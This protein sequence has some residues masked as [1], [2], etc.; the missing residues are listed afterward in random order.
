MEELQAEM[1][2]VKA[3]WGKE[4]ELSKAEKGAPGFPFPVAV[5]RYAPQPEHAAMWDCEELPF[6]L[7]IFEKEVENLPVSVEVP[8][9]FP[10]D[11]SS[12]MERAIETE[13]RK[14][15]GKK[16]K[17]N[18][19]MVEE[20]CEWVEAKFG[21]LLRLNPEYVDHYFGCDAAGASM[22]RYTLVGPAPD[23]EEEPDEEDLTPE[24]QERRLQEYLEREQ[25]RI[26]AEIEEKIAADAEK[27]RLA[28]KGIFE[29]GEKARQ[30]SKAEKAELNKTRK[31]R[32]GHRWRKT[33]PKAHKP[34]RED[35]EKALKGL[36]GHK[37]K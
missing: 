34:V 13:W 18:M 29:D 17:P 25:A 28:E 6:R 31:E 24:E 30:L 27:R 2:A 20:I 37:K 4:I 8:P 35:P 26:E 10:G 5:T 12:L 7:V 1:K 11:L 21:D 36:P 16:K 33:G 3:R 9:I 22:R 23:E 19:W 32:S 14:Q 15:L